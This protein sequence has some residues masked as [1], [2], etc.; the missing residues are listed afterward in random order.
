VTSL[1]RFEVPRELRSD[2]GNNFQ[3]L[4]RLENLRRLGMCKMTGVT[5]TYL[6]AYVTGSNDSVLGKLGRTTAV[7]GGEASWT[8]RCVET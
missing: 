4:L 1:L 7:S 8:R 2:Q 3:S 5:V 6:R